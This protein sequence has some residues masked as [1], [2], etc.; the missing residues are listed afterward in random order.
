MVFNPVIIRHLNMKAGCDVTTAAGATIL[1]HDI[2]SKTGEKLAANTLKRLL[3]II[4]YN[5]TPRL[6]TLNIIGR[7]LGYQSWEDFYSAIKKGISIYG[8]HNPCVEVRKLPTDA[9]ITIRWDANKEVKIRHHGGRICE[10]V[11]ITNCDLIPIGNRIGNRIRKNNLMEGDIVVMPQIAVG[12]PLALKSVLREGY[13]I[14]KGVIAPEI[15][16]EDIKV[17][18]GGMRIL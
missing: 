3:G 18:Y 4:P 9:L 7:Y 14:G 12:L 17:E 16:I 1:A 11:Q 5:N 8:D 6:T 13:I 10:V 2:E 15:G